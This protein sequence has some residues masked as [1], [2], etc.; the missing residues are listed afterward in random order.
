MIELIATL[1]LI[2]A[3]AVVAAIFAACICLLTGR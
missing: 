2:V 3:A 1:F